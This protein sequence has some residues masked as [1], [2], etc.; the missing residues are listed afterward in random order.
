MALQDYAKLV[1]LL[2][3]TEIEE[4]TNI[5]LKTNGGWMP[6]KTLKKG[7][8]G[9][10]KSSGEVTLNVQF[11]VPLGGPEVNFQSKCIE[12]EYVT[13]QVGIGAIDYVGNGKIMNVDIS[14]STDKEISGSFSWMGEVNKM[15]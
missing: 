13:M 5:D 8:T 6:V 9:F 11:T 7:L 12:G 10:S 14:Q 3:G 15:Q 2:D 4:V 1:V